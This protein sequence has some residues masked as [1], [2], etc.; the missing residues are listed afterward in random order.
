M[1]GLVYAIGGFSHKDLPH[2]LPVTLAS[3]ERYSIVEN[4]WV[5]VSTMSEPRAFSAHIVLDNQFIYIFGGMHDFNILQTIEKYDTIAD[6]W[7][8]VYFM[9]PRP[10][11]KLGACLIDREA[12]FI[13]GGM[14]SD[15]EA[16]KEVYTFSLEHTTWKRKS[17]LPIAKLVSTGCGYS[18]RNPGGHIYVIGGTIDQSCERYS[19]AE[20]KWKEIPSYKKLTAIGNGLFSYAIVMTPK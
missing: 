1:N 16:R 20:D 3:V 15:F 18:S 5:Y 4:A 13:C 11:A 10:L 14:S 17:D 7:V 8:T 19:V 9:L 2:E 12:I 6:T